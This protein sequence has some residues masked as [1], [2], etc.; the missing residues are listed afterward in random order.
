MALGI[1][2]IAIS[3][4]GNGP[5]DAVNIGLSEKTGL[6]IGLCMNI[7]A[8]I[9]IIIGGIIRKEFPKYSNYDNFY[10]FRII[11]RFLDVIFRA[12]LL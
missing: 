5:W 7:V 3:N 4:F 10:I 12:I 6:S 9:Q 1:S 8:F 2:I 11:C